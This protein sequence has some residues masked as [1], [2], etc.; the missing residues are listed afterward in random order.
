M[1]KLLG[2]A[3]LGAWI[4]TETATSTS[5]GAQATVPGDTDG[6]VVKLNLA[7]LGYKRVLPSRDGANAVVAAPSEVYVAGFHDVVLGAA[8]RGNIDP[9]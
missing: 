6:F 1:Y 4:L 7:A 8:N 2:G 3:L 5:R 9:S